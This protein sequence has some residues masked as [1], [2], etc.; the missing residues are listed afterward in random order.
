MKNS[1]SKKQARKKGKLNPLVAAG[2]IIGTGVAVAGAV[3]MSDKK[4]QKKV[5]E[6]TDNIKKQMKV[7]KNEVIKKAKK[8]E[9]IIKDAADEVK[10]I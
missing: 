7:K 10:K 5:K 6:M 1:N 8:V 9:A 2:A 3:A 4:N